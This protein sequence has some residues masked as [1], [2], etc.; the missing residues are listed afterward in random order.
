[1]QFDTL[2]GDDSREAANTR[3]DTES[4][5]APSVCPGC[6]GA[7]HRW[8][9][10]ERV[11]MDPGAQ[12]IFLAGLRDGTDDPPLTDGRALLQCLGATLFGGREFNVFV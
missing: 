11:F 9:P 10:E 12:N 4:V 1:M 3:F 6:G 8:C 2:R 7:G 5:N